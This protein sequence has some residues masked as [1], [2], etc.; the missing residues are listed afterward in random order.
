MPGIR[1]IH[2][3][4]RPK[5]DE[6]RARH[7][8]RCAGIGRRILFHGGNG[9]ATPLSRYA[10]APSCPDEGRQSRTRSDRL[11][12]FAASRESARRIEVDRDLA[13]CSNVR[14]NRFAT[15]R[16]GD[17]AL[18]TP[19]M[20]VIFAC[21]VVLASL[22]VAIA[23]WTIVA[24]TAFTAI[25]VFMVYGLLLAIAWVALSAVDVALTE[26]AIGGGVTSMLLMG[27]A[28]RL[29]APKAPVE[30]VGLP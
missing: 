30:D 12:P 10:H 25:V 18:R 3:Q 8:Y 13:A 28:T 5:I 7:Y 1:P 26:A 6:A 16:A 9:R 22:L 14:R 2:L 17:A 4:T 24:R 19:D 21:E 11:R 23:T 29:R 15:Y 27:A 20:T